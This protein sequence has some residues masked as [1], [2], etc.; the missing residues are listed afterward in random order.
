MSIS[1]TTSW[2][3]TWNACY[4]SFVSLI[5]SPADLLLAARGLRSFGDGLISL[6]LPVYLLV[7]GYGAVATGVIATATLL[8]SALLTM[9]VGV[10]GNRVHGRTLLLGAALLMAATGVVFAYVHDLWPLVIVAFVGTL[11][12]SAGDVSVFLPL[13]QAELARTVQS[14]DRTRLFARYSFI[15]SVT[16]A[17][18]ALAAGFPEG[19]ADLFGVDKKTALQSAF[20]TY[21]A[22]G[23]AVFA[24]YAQLPRYPK[25]AASAHRG[26]SLRQS[27]RPV[28]TLAALFSLDAFAGGFVVQSLLAL[29]LFE[30]FNL[31]L[32]MAGLIFFWTGLLSS[33][34]Y[35]VAAR[36]AERIG[37]VNTMVFTHLPSNIC[38]VLTAFAPTLWMAVALLLLRSALSQMDVRRAPFAGVCHVGSWARLGL[39]RLGSVCLGWSGSASLLPLSA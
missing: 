13:E 20:L 18:G 27:R 11:N 15:G 29:W 22:L 23:V 19:A 9:L 24:I 26:H 38:L 34:S 3:N 30:R 32:A 37:L 5:A 35:F 25:R 16:A 1:V 8:G 14:Q 2:T 12:P 31:S 39:R 10:H 33:F 17:V 7:L 21:A 6:V 28:L 36:I 4:S